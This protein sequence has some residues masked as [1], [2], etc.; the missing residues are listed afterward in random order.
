MESLRCL[1]LN[2]VI[3][4][5]LNYKD[6]PAELMEDLNKMKQFNGQFSMPSIEHSSG[7]CE[8]QGCIKFTLLIPGGEGKNI[9]V[10]AI[11]GKNIQDL[12]RN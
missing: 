6:L 11:L 10:R 8:A 7:L 2:A 1:S 5:E 9:R 4:H 3:K 12:V